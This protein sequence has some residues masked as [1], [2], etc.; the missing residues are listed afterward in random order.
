MDFRRDNLTRI[1]RA[2][3]KLN[4]LLDLLGRRDDGFH[5]LETIMV[6]IRLCDSVAFLPTK[7]SNDG[8][9]PEITLSV[10]MCG[11]G[12][13][14]TKS[15]A[16]PEGRDN[17]IVRT[18]ELLRQRSGCE[19]G[20]QVELIKRVPPAAGLGGGSSDAAAALRLANW[21]WGL[22]WDVDRLAE[23]A[24][25]IGSDVPFFLYGG[26]AVCRGRGERVESLPATSPI[27][28]VVVKPPVGLA[29]S[30]VYRARAQISK[31]GNGTTKPE[32]TLASVAKELACGNGARWGRRMRNDLQQAA[33]SLT[34]WVDR[35]KAAFDSLDFAGHQLS[36]SGTAYFGVCR[37]A[38][39]ARRLANILRTRQLGLVYATRS[40]Q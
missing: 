3:A 30:D 19:L 33:S 39:H 5:E 13:A 32:G 15:E 26:A 10:R 7:H 11:P 36:G 6:P 28:F 22:S 4:L 25:E 8:D 2:P 24:A 14:D 16:I 18:L 29:T 34:P 31:S 12:G 23:I 17:I 35:M 1:A 37:H 21:G 40:C 20:A 38:Q 9:A 27:H